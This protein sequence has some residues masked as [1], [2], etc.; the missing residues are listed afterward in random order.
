MLCA[1]GE[2]DFKSCLHTYAGIITCEEI[3]HLDDYPGKVVDNDGYARSKD[4][5]ALSPS[6]K[7]AAEDHTYSAT[8]KPVHEIPTYP[9]IYNY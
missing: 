8:V 3:G 2:T 7:C 6:I 5:D 4:S 9:L 1:Y